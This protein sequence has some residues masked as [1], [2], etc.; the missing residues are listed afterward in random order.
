MRGT[1]TGTAQSGFWLCWRMTSLKANTENKINI[2]TFASFSLWKHRVVEA[3]WYYL[4]RCQPAGGIP[5]LVRSIWIQIHSPRREN[6]SS[7]QTSLQGRTVSVPQEVHLSEPLQDH[8]QAHWFPIEVWKWITNTRR[9]PIHF[10]GVIVPC[11]PQQQSKHLKRSLSLCRSCFTVCSLSG[12][13]RLKE[14]KRQTWAKAETGETTSW[15]G[16]MLTWYMI[17]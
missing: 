10:C 11:L 13:P 5:T 3:E 2:Q 12:G 17:T 1:Q 16:F 7:K 4:Y 6:K 14:L 15:P 8:Q 9:W